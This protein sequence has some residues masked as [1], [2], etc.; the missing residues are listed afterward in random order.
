MSDE[1]KQQNQQGGK[2]SQQQGSGGQKSGPRQ[3]E[4]IQK[5]GFIPEGEEEGGAAKVPAGVGLH[6]SE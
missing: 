1:R 5:P 2:G 4:P 6:L 3:R